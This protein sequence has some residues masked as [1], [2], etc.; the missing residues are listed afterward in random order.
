[1]SIRT[2]LLT[3][4]AT[5]LAIGLLAAPGPAYSRDEAIA[6]PGKKASSHTVT[7]PGQ[8]RAEPAR[9]DACGA[10]AALARCLIMPAADRLLAD[11]GAAAGEPYDT[12]GNLLDRHGYVLAA[13][14]TR[15]AREVFVATDR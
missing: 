5:G 8:M 4:L 11:H 15:G 12:Q 2:R 9:S 14:E 1:M 7:V 6:V 13:P 10:V 3:A